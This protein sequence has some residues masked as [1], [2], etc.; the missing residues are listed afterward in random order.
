MRDFYQGNAQIP[1]W[2]Q[3][4][5]ALGVPVRLAVAQQEEA[6]PCA[7]RLQRACC[8][9]AEGKQEHAWS[10]ALCVA[11]GFAARYFRSLT[12]RLPGEEGQRNE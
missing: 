6:P 4:V 1:R 10:A 7:A 2:C 8:R 12:P 9:H 3:V 11:G 5:P